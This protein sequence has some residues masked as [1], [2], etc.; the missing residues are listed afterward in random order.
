MDEMSTKIQA[1]CLHRLFSKFER[2][3][4][5]DEC[6]IMKRPSLAANTASF[7][8]IPNNQKLSLYYHTFV[9]KCSKWD[10]PQFI[11]DFVDFK[12]VLSQRNKEGTTI[13]IIISSVTLLFATRL[14]TLT[15]KM[16]LKENAL[17]LSFKISNV[18]V[19]L[20]LWDDY[21]K[22]MCSYMLSQDR[23]AHVVIAVHFGAVKTYKGKWGISNNFDGTR[24][25]INDNFDQMLTFK[26]KFI[27]KLS[28]SAESSSHVGSYVI[29]SVEDEFV[30]NDVFSPIAYIGSIIQPKKV[31]IVGT[32]VAIVSDKM[33]YYDK[34]NYCK[35]KVEQNF[36]T[37][38]KEDGTSDVRDEKV[39][40]C[41][42]KDCQGKDVFPN[43]EVLKFVGKTA[44]EI[45]QI[46][47]DILKTNEMPRAYPVEF[48]T[49][50]N[51]KCAFIIRVTDF[52]ITNA[53]ENYGISV[54]TNDADI[55]DQ[56]NKKWKIDQLDAS[57]S[58]AMSQSDFQDAGGES[59]KDG[60]SYTG[61]NSTPVSKDF[62][63]D[64]NQSSTYLKRN[65]GD[66]Y[67]SEDVVG[68]SASK[69]RI[70][71]DTISS[72]EGHAKN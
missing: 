51:L 9:E 49:L 10:G 40:Q 38:D 5:V 69:P 18:E 55:L 20:T 25:F 35:S 31:V 28:A 32:I 16:V 60:V 3:L 61:D 62:A 66:V 27:A 11:F 59:A 4:N 36:E 64:L 26:E 33:W 58:F 17:I 71:G 12:D 63:S 37:Y 68:S 47:H 45:I 50:V 46:Q 42:N 70:S 30:N 44:K 57:D 52:N 19:D 15:K 7:K 54:V 34:C 13:G 65:L 22:D 56:L 1:S 41:S 43:V 8:I 2:H 21:A 53:V 67:A 72:D 23:E 48:D 29:C 14:R 39:Y 6:L 24:L